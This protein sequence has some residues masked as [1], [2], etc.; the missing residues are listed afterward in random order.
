MKRSSRFNPVLIFF[1]L[2][3]VV[4]SG[5]TL[6]VMSP[7]QVTVSKRLSEG[8]DLGPGQGRDHR[9]L[10]HHPDNRH[11]GQT[12]TALQTQLGPL[13][14]AT[15]GSNF[16]GVGASGVAPS[17]ANMAV[18]GNPAYDYIFQTVNSR[19]AIYTK[20]GAL[21][22]G[23]NSLSSLWAPLG[24]GNGC[25]TNNGGDVV[26]QYDKFADRWIV[27]QLGGVSQP[28]SE[29]IAVSQTADPTGVYYLYSF[30][31]GNTLN[32][33]PKFGVWPTASNGAYVATFN[34]FGNNGN[35]FT[36]GQLC[37]YDR[38][39]ML[40]GDPGA[41]AICF[42]LNGDGGYLPAD[43]DGSTAPLDGTPALFLNYPSLSS[44]RMYALAPDFANPNSSTLT[45]ITPDLAVTPFS[46]ACGAGVCIPQSGTSQQLDSLGD[47]L[48][49][50][51]AF[52]N[53]GDH[54][55]LVV[56]HSVANGSSAGVRWYELRSPVSTTP[57][58]TL[59]QQGTYAPDATY[60]W[61][62]SAAM[63]AA[64]DIGLGYSASSSS[65]HPAVRYTGRVPGDPAGTMESEASIIEG[66]GSQTGGLDRWGDY[67]ALRID[68]ADD[69]TFWY[70]TQYEATSGSFN[71]HTRVGSFKFTSC[72]AQVVTPTFS[73][74]AGTYT[75]AQSVT[76]STTTSGASIR[77]TTDGSTPTSSV[78]TLYSSPVSVSSSLTLKAIAYKAGMTDSLVASAA[79]TISGG[80][81]GPSWYNPSWTNR[82]T[83]TI[84][85]TKVS[86]SSSLANFPVLFSVTDAN[87][88]SVANGGNV[89][90]TDGTD[91]LFTASDGITKLDHELESY[92]PG[93]GQIVAWVRVPTLSPVTDTV[94]YIYY[95]NAGS[96]DQQNKA[97]V[98]DSAYRGVYHLKDTLTS[99]GQT[100]S[101]STS[102]AFQGLSVG[103]WGSSQQAGGKVGGGLRFDGSSDAV[104]LKSLA[105]SG[106]TYTVS[107]WTNPVSNSGYIF[108]SYTAQR[109]VVDLGDYAP[110]PNAL[111]VYDA[112]AWLSLSNALS[113]SQW[114]YVTLVLNS[115]TGAI[116]GYVN[117]IA[118]GTGAYSVTTSHSN[119]AQ[120]LGSAA[121]S[122][123]WFNGMLDEF[124]VSTTARTAA[125]I[126]TEYG[127]QNTPA[128]FYAVGTQETSGG[129]AQVTTPTFN[130]PG[131]T[132]SSAQSVTIS[133]ATSG[134]TI[135]YTT[136]GSTPTSSVGTL[137]SGPVA[138]SS[139]LTLKAIAYKTGMTDIGDHQLK[140]AVWDSTYRT[141]IH[142]A[143]N[144]AGQSAQHQQVSECNGDRK[145]Y[146]L[147][148]AWRQDQLVHQGDHGQRRQSGVTLVPNPAAGSFV[149]L[150]GSAAY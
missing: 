77:Y 34:L 48:M 51:L 106:G 137:Y 122:Y 110:V 132:Y 17:D 3:G 79:Y 101:D 65:I 62:G 2:T 117:G 39:K 83:I 10:P 9:L 73:P 99:S 26:A 85:H 130:P 42:T 43:L 78:G 103:S 27:T 56:N 141:L 115:G 102:N 126:L 59:F 68:P 81:G 47:R 121:S 53:F 139:S 36:G 75:S 136:D 58:F 71:W 64:G 5:Q 112:G 87:L 11:T 20:S 129:S 37:A 1:A 18:G 84:D 6:T 127:N 8:T 25:A 13:I 32:D 22:V 70:T 100:V 4:A 40:A 94:L 61:M 131:G 14:N 52:R 49:Y 33:Y 91:I 38:T 69:C 24:S 86:G 72:G 31:Y 45:H 12:D 15:G 140:T 63:D 88:K 123:A 50:R 98:W 147:V 46:E 120:T 108:D 150:S 146:W 76:I 92:N 134:A 90:K 54:E 89:G 114:I 7:S 95:G 41:Q 16:D 133:T 138:V 93:T 149:N 19:Y 105:F 107:F 21:V 119:E 60:R 125:W 80:G 128:T 135:R 148:D 142:L 82:K 96:V 118:T 57:N 28:Y 143:D 144:V 55:A 111:G 29:C 113:P 74:V 35:T 145:R 124:R 23:P 97:G 109:L 66:A 44:L 104:D 67:S 30:S 116:T